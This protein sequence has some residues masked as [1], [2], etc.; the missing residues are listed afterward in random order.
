LVTTKGPFAAIKL[1][2][3]K[4]KAETFAAWLTP[5]TPF[6][7]VS[8][9][10]GGAFW[11]GGVDGSHPPAFG[12]PC[13]CYSRLSRMPGL[14]PGEAWHFFSGSIWL[15][16]RGKAT[17]EAQRTLTI[18]TCV[19]GA[20]FE[21]ATSSQQYERIF[22]HMLAEPSLSRDANTHQNIRS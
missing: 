14:M 10:A 20:M 4:Q 5:K 12:Y 7:L 18:R 19:P 6:G 21:L 13:L 1:I 2:D 8:P 15:L 22:F 16:V 3:A 9:H 11:R 17:E